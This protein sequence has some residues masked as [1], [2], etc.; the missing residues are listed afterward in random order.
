MAHIPIHTGD[1][2]AD[3]LEKFDMNAAELARAIHVPPNR[4][5]QIVAKKRDVTADTALR[6]GK[7]F[8]TSPHLWLKL[9][10][11]YELYMA[12]KK[13]SR[14]LDEISTLDAGAEVKTK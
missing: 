1:F 3:K 2:L 8:G 14:L 12:R 7:W 10:Q 5:S 4:I 13:I 6:L 9:Q 11:A